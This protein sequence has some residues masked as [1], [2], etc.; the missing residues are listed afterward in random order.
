M[1]RRLP[2]VVLALVALPGRPLEA[3]TPDAAPLAPDALVDLQ[4]YPPYFDALMAEL[5][6]AGLS[7]SKTIPHLSVMDDGVRVMPVHV[8]VSGDLSQITALLASLSSDRFPFKSRVG[9]L[10]LGR[11]LETEGARNG[12]KPFRAEVMLLAPVRPRQ[13][14]PLSEDVA[15]RVAADRRHGEALAALLKGLLTAKSAAPWLMTLRIDGH[16]VAI[17]GAIPEKASAH[18]IV[19]RVV[20]LEG[21][22]VSE[23]IGPQVD[24]ESKRTV[25]LALGRLD[26][27]APRPAPSRAATDPARRSSGG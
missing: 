10:S 15:A 25:F 8:G 5:S 14:E 19:E 17:E 22:V 13:G 18:G 16:D 20:S 24:P 12:G 21:F 7:G 4:D 1:G 23:V 27:P 2:V 3:T 6:R 26:A 9:E 11:A